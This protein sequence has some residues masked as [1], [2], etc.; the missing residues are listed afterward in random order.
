MR[1]LFL[2]KQSIIIKEVAQP[3]LDD[4]LVLVSVHYSFISSGTESA[5]LLSASTNSLTSNISRKAYK[6][7]ESLLT[8]GINETKAAITRNVQGTVQNLG[9]SCSGRVIAVGKKVKQVRAGDFVAC[10][11]AGFANHA[12]IICVPENLVTRIAD[13]K[14]LEHAS[15]TTIGAIALQGIRRTQPQLG[16]IIC[17]QGLG[18]LGQITVQLAK[19]SGCTVLGIDLLPER[20]ELA[21]QLGADAVFNASSETL[22]K[23]IAFFTN[24]HGVDATLITAAS[25]SNALVQQAMEITR[26]KGKVV[27]VGDV[28]LGLERAPLYQKE[29]DFLISCSYGPGRYDAQYEKEGNDYPYAFVRWTENRNMQAF[30]QLIQTNKIAIAPLISETVSL[31]NAAEAYSKLQNK[32]MLGMVLKYLPKEEQVFDN[33]CNEKKLD[34]Q[35][36]FTPAQKDTIRIGVIGAGGFSKSVLMPIAQQIKGALFTAIVDS[37]I[38]NSINTSRQFGAA[39]AL[40]DDRELFNNDYS[41][42]IIIASPHK[43]HCDQI[44]N[45]LEHNKAVFV[46]KPMVTTFEQLERLTPF[47]EKNSIPFCVDYNRSYAPFVRAIREQ[48]GKRSSP[49]VVHYRMNVGFIPKEHWIQTEV[50]AERIIGEACHIVDLFCS[51]TDS[52]P[53]SVSVETVKPRAENLFVTDNFSAQ[54]SFA[55]GSLCTLLYTALGHA[56]MGKERMEVYFDSKTIVMDDYKTLQGFGIPDSFNQTVKA[57][58]KGHTYLLKTFFASVQSY[59]SKPVMTFDRLHTSAYLTLVIDQL[60]RGGGGEK[61]L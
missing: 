33:I 25:S 19:L 10:A 21:T 7:I 39:Q 44:I 50:G 34:K 30:V 28:G 23:D 26:K 37:D 38:S 20:L 51:L 12:D 31:E 29:I 55:D 59:D 15:I 6:V 57:P 3:I 32:K 11:G 45:A 17:V 48:I 13:E 56:G 36:H 61:S 41:D 4:T 16:E 58:D 9:Y 40:T 27:L 46:E 14:F 35:Y 49:L 60:A 2:E 5:T 8:K 47:L 52:K 1:Q 22:Q 42:V 53:V 18:L 24:H 43:Y 54:I